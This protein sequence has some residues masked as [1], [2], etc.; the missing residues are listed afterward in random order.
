MS[1]KPWLKKKQQKPNPECPGGAKGF[2]LWAQQGRLQLPAVPP[3]V[4]PEPAWGQLGTLR[5]HCTDLTACGTSAH[6]PSTS[7][8]PHLSAA[9]KSSSGSS[10]FLSRAPNPGSH[11]HSPR[12][13][14]EGI[15]ISLQP[16]LLC[17]GAFP[18]WGPSSQPQ[19][20]DSRLFLLKKPILVHLLSHWSVMQPRS[21]WVIPQHSISLDLG[22]RSLGTVW[23]QSLSSAPGQVKSRGCV[24]VLNQTLLLCRDTGKAAVAE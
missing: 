8:L 23:G 3:S 24:C 10:T 17:H 5:G 1:P 11:P 19:A 12:S 22:C 4:C 16:R 14:L 7:L 20:A 21:H 18:V 13:Y 6:P 9:G 15:L 2:Q